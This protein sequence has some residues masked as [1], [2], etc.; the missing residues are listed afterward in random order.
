VSRFARLECNYLSDPDP[1]R[2]NGIANADRLA[3]WLARSSREPNRTIHC[4]RGEDA[5]PKGP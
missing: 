1:E 5:V 4:P 2:M 3:A